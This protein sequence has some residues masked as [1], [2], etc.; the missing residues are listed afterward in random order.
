[1][2]KRYSFINMAVGL[3]GQMI[4]VILA[5][6]SRMIFVK[7]L[8]S[9]ELGVNGLFDNIFSMISLAELGIG[10]AMIYSLYK[11]V[12]EDD[13]DMVCRLMNLYKLLYRAVAVFVFA[14]GLLLFPFLGYFIKGDTGID[15]LNVIYFMYLGNSVASYLLSYKASMLIANQKVY[16]KIIYE[17]IIHTIQ[18]IAQIIILVTT[19]NLI[20][21]LSMQILN[22]I[23]VNWMV[24]RKVDKEYTYLKDTKE[25]PSKETCK[26]IG[27]NIMALGMHKFGGVVVSGTDNLLM[28]AFVGLKSVGIYSNY[29]LILVNVNYLLNKIYNAFSGSIGN[30]GATENK[31]KIYNIYCILDFAVFWLY[32]Y[33]AV[34]L[35]VVLNPF[36]EL[37]F[38][39]E[40]LFSI[41]FVLILLTEFYITGMRQITT[42]FRSALGLFWYDRYKP[43]AEG[44]VNLV[45]SIILVQKMGIAGIFLGTIISSLTVCFWVEPYILMKYG[46]IDEWKKKLMRYFTTYGIRTFSVCV[47]GFVTYYICSKISG[48]NIGWIIVKGITSTLIYNIIFVLLYFRTREFKD[49]Y[50]SL[51]EFLN[52]K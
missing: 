17:Q 49:L 12:A 22:Q 44:I 9:E 50:G 15:H 2:R 40:Y 6:F 42:Q 20:L 38:G 19:K 37:C 18:I 43:L 8:S 26:A 31:N 46:I 27:K 1:M 14:A 45:T 36:I 29:K 3:G 13:R 5:F 51:R 11:P 24:S 39:K 52:K 34:E 48:E 10:A 33:V 28:S 47:I 16:F 35:L 25:L 7:Y 32:G 23:L 41:S 21:Y 4:N 30:L